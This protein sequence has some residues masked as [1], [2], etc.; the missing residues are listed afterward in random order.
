M[1]RSD[2]EMN[3]ASVMAAHVL[4]NDQGALRTLISM[5]HDRIEF[6]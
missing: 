6:A 5:G 3:Q 1:F 4:S 2:D